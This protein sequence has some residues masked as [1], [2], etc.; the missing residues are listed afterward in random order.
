M[1]I[2]KLLEEMPKEKLE[3]A[4]EFKER[5]FRHPNPVEYVNNMYG[6]HPGDGGVGYFQNIYG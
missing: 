5:M 3:R 1:N 4:K 6:C 2:D